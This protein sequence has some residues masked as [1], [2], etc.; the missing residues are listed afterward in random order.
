M[1]HRQ[2]FV[3]RDTDK[4]FSDHLDHI[5]DFD[6]YQVLC[7]EK[8]RHLRKLKEAIY[9]SKDHDFAID[10]KSNWKTNKNLGKD[11]SPIWIPIVDR[12]V[13]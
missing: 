7:N 1:E 6:N 13:S 2:S 12:L 4:A 9:I 10:S 11:F 8:N 5:P 3:H